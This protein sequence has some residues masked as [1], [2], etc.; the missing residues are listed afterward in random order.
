MASLYRDPV[1][2]LFG[3]IRVTLDD[4]RAWVAAMS[5]V[6]LEERNYENYLRRYNVADKVRAAKRSGEFDTII[7]NIKPT[8]LI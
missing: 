1:A 2:D 4:L 7:T 5:P 8:R 6:N 3:E